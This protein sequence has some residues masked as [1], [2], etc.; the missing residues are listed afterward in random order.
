V[1]T[2]Q[3]AGLRR[4]IV[5]GGIGFLLLGLLLTTIL[6]KK[7]YLEIVRTRRQI[8]ELT[9]RIE[10]LEREKIRLA[11]EIAE[12]RNNPEAVDREAREKLW[13]LKPD[14]KVIIRK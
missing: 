14:E 6:G 2:G 1:R 10:D 9:R 3:P 12:L 13:L 11:R 8:A 4:K 5:A 7:G